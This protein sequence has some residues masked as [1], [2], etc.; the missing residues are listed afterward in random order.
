MAKR[1]VAELRVAESINLD[2]RK[3]YVDFYGITLILYSLG[4]VR[5]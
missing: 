2:L 5:I 4:N 1:G 3:I